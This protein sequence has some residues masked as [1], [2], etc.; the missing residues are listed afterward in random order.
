ML[1]GAE[2]LGHQHD[3][4]GALT[5]AVDGAVH[6]AAA[7]VVVGSQVGGGARHVHSQPP[8]GRGESG[9]EDPVYPPATLA[10]RVVVEDGYV[11][12]TA[13]WSVVAGSPHALQA[14]PGVEDGGDHTPEPVSPQRQQDQ[15]RQSDEQHAHRRLGQA[16]VVVVAAVEELFL[17]LDE[18]AAGVAVAV[19]GV[20]VVNALGVGSQP[21]EEL[22]VVAVAPPGVSGEP[23]A[24]QRLQLAQLSNRVR[25]QRRQGVVRQ[26]QALQL[27]HV[28]QE[29]VRQL[30]K[31]VPAEGQRG[32]VGQGSKEPWRQLAQVVVVQLK[33]GE[34][35][36]VVES[37]G[38]EPRDA[39]V[40]EVQLLHHQRHGRLVVNDFP[41][42]P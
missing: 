7:A 14:Q 30:A 17:R 33:E 26:V 8:G 15:R 13:E 11:V 37:G 36:E 32:E 12:E 4:H 40:V 28:A 22:G 5:H 38:G 10:V 31:A 35:A 2:V 3:A 41:H 24:S 34:V 9:D 1:V 23:Q 21:V 27:L 6:H 29:L 25:R 19:H 39:A 42:L 20:V 16:V 18:P